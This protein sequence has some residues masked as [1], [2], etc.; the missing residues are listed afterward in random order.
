MKVRRNWVGADL[1]VCPVHPMGVTHL[2]KEDPT[3]MDL[4]LSG[5]VAI[6]TGGSMGIGK[7]AA[8]ALHRE[9]VKEARGMRAIS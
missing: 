6:I 8:T 1:C 5:K 4:G 7:A 2:S 3:T 9:G